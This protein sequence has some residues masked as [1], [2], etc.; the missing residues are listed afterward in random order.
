MKKKYSDLNRKQ[1]IIVTITGI[2][3]VLLILM[4]LTY[5]YFLTQIK[6]NEN[7]K[8]ISV[9][10]ANL[11]LVYGDGNGLI[12]PEGKIIPGTTI[13]SKTF[14]VK[15]EGNTTINNYAVVLEKFIVKNATTGVATTLNSPSDFK[16]TVTCKSDVK[17]K[18]CEGTETNLT[19]ANILILTNSI[20][21]G[22]TQSYEL[23]LEYQE[24]GVD[25]SADMNK[26][27]E[28][29]VNIMDTN[30]TVDIEGI[31][32]THADGDYIQVNSTPKVSYITKNGS[33]KVLG[34]EPGNHT[35]SY[36]SKDGIKKGS[37]DF[38]IMLGDSANVSGTTITI[39]S[40]TRTATI[41]VSSSYTF[42]I[43]S[44]LK[45]LFANLYDTIIASANAANSVEDTKRT[46]YTE[47]QK[48]RT[49]NESLLE[50]AEEKDTQIYAYADAELGWYHDYEERGIFYDEERTTCDELKGKYAILFTQNYSSTFSKEYYVEE[51]NG[52]V[53]IVQ[54]TSVRNLLKTTDEEGESYYY[55]GEVID[56]YV[57][58]A[59][60]LWRILRTHADG[61]I[62]LVLNTTYNSSN[63]GYEKVDGNTNI[64]KEK[65]INSSS[66]S[67]METLKKY[68]ETNLSNYL[69]Y[70]KLENWCYGNT[71]YSNKGGTKLSL[72][73]M[74]NN[75]NSFTPMYYSSYVN[76][77]PTD[78]NCDGTII[79]KYED[80]SNMYVGTITANE[81]RLANSNSDNFISG[82]STISIWTMS[83]GK[84]G[85]SG[86]LYWADQ[87][88]IVDGNGSISL[89]GLDYGYTG[90]S[91][92]YV[93]Y[94]NF[95]LPSITLKPEIGVKSG[96]GTKNNPYVID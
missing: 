82:Y 9:S 38:Q 48:S 32:A 5:A 50:I 43:S 42:I 27:I 22:E 41:D 58:F 2:F 88:Y 3:L 21:E 63:F 95:V 15:N 33:F 31:A 53:P 30:N 17:N 76:T 1:K 25:Q 57:S 86:N 66:D 39:T 14:T 60:K 18:K 68:Q 87:A 26:T 83:L 61:S 71:A 73:T 51:C 46:I 28:A 44:K 78:L 12:A 90:Y 74:Q 84:Y 4:G 81:A 29:K 72:D 59:G 79:N 75:Y 80:G 34:I 35:I 56:N 69:N 62:K 37:Q 67:L 40:S 96:D 89:D 94:A 93:H 70:L 55:K 11:V 85:N 54:N 7:N 45:N 77:N 19:G 8:S 49:I 52:E 20:D 13:E 91:H 24:T 36:Y 16:I 6:G 65:F 64:Y 92:G 47:I 23:V 10:T